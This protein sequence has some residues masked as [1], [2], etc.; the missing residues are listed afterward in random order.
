MAR[1]LKIGR[2]LGSAAAAA[3]MF[4]TFSTLSTGS[5]VADTPLHL[6]NYNSN[7]CLGISG[8]GTGWG[9]PAIQWSCNH[10]NDQLW[11]TVPTGSGYELVNSNGLCLEAPGWTTA[12]GAQL[13]QWQCS[14]GANQI[15]TTNGNQWSNIQIKNVH[16]NLC[17]SAQGGSQSDGAAIIQWNCSDVFDQFWYWDANA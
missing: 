14:G 9:T 16:S 6:K 11:T 13:G 5:A 10:N 15:W 3:A 17:I 8:G 7:K 4:L 1:K 12:P 2:L